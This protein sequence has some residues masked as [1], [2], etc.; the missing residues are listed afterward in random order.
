ME[1]QTLWLKYQ[2]PYLEFQPPDLYGHVPCFDIEIHTWSARFRIMLGGWDSTCGMPG[3]SFVNG[4]SNN[5]FEIYVSK[6]RNSG[7]FFVWFCFHILCLLTYLENQI[8]LLQISSYECKTLY[9]CNLPKILGSIL[10][11]EGSKP[12]WLRSMLSGPD[13]LPRGSGSNLEG[14]VPSLERVLSHRLPWNDCKA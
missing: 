5:Y 1:K 4:E 3:S 12:G 13:D 7:G 9:P 10:G 11:M 8:L 6:V 14:Q 2:I